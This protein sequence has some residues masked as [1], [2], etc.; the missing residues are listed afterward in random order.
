M[1]LGVA[2]HAASFA[3]LRELLFRVIVII[4]RF[5]LHSARNGR[6]AFSFLR[7]CINVRFRKTTPRKNRIV[8]SCISIIILLVIGFV[9]CQHSQILIELFAIRTLVE[10]FV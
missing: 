10:V 5:Y 4:K 2:I 3:T 6:N 7:N 8:S 9:S 1:L